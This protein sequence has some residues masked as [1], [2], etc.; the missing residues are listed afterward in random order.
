MTRKGPLIF[1]EMSLYFLCKMSGDRV[2]LPGNTWFSSWVGGE[3]KQA[4]IFRRS[5]IS[6]VLTTGTFHV[7]RSMC[8]HIP[9]KIP[10]K[11]SMQN[12][13]IIENDSVP[14]F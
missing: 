4:E 11:I 6:K 2:H 14:P 1:F 5:E 3:T 9:W 13:M 12:N 10:R 8:R 7:R